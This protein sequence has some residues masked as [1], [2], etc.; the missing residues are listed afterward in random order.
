VTELAFI[1]GAVFMRE[2]L[3]KR[4][5]KQ[6]DALASKLESDIAAASL[7]STKSK[8]GAPGAEQAVALGKSLVEQLRSTKAAGR[9]VIN[10]RKVMQSK[11]DVIDQEQEGYYPDIDD[12]NL[13]VKNGDKLVI[14]RKTQSVTVL[15]EVHYPTSHLYDDTLER[16]DYI[17][18]S[19]GVTYK[20]DNKRI[21]IVRAN[22]E[23]IAE[24]DSFWSF[25]DVSTEIRR[26]DTVIVPLDA[27]RV[28]TITLWTNVTQIL[29]QV[30]VA[31]AAFTSAG[32]F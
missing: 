12:D 6:M 2:E 1:D 8:E 26:G 23:V 10:L 27:E 5:Q 4:E 9:L 30:G 32:I 31:L 28:K 17:G 16:D 11:V 29:Y 19:G 21:Y 25:D 3:R 13:L 18:R 7:E 14:P 22:G 20:A 24:N 15:G